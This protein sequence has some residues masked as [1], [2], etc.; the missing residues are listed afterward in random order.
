MNFQLK[1]HV[2]QGLPLLMEARFSYFALSLPHSH[3]ATSIKSFEY[4][5]DSPT[6]VLEGKKNAYGPY[7]IN[8]LVP[9]A[10]YTPHALGCSKH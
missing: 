2:R 1:A 8:P 6:Y 9:N 10:R 5:A 4:L 7:S 3:T